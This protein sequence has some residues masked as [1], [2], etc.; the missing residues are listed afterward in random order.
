MLKSWVPSAQSKVWALQARVSLSLWSVQG[1]TGITSNIAEEWLQKTASTAGENV[2]RP[3]DV[4]SAVLM[5][6]NVSST[7][8]TVR[9]ILSAKTTGIHPI[10][11]M[12]WKRNLS[13]RVPILRGSPRELT[14]SR[15][16]PASSLS[17]FNL[18]IPT[19]RSWWRKR[20]RM[21]TEYPGKKKT[22]RKRWN[23]CWIFM[24]GGHL[25]R[26]S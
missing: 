4:T 6:K 12:L 22:W 25:S 20:I 14:G 9:S 11:S 13:I 1:L 17:T 7:V 23:G 2:S 10:L 5:I 15:Q 3:R 8:M 21:D 16:E 26:S 24:K 18:N 19:V